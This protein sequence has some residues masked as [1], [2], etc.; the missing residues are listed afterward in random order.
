[1]KPL[2]VS[3][4]SLLVLA[5][6]ALFAESATSDPRTSLSIGYTGAPTDHGGKDCSTCHNSFASNSDGSGSVTLQVAPYNPSTIQTIKVIVNH[7]HARR[8][9]FQLTARLVSDQTKLAGSFTASGMNTQVR[10]DNGT[11][12]GAPAPA[13]VSGQIEYAEHLNAPTTTLGAGFTFDIQ[14]MPPNPEVGKVIFYVS[15]VAA[16][17]DN[18]PLGDHVYT[19]TKTVDFTGGCTATKAPTIRTVVNGASFQTSFSSNAIITVYGDGFTQAGPR[20]AGLGDFENGAFPTVL[21]CVALEMMGPGQEHYVRLPITY[22]ERGQVNA[23]APRFTGVGTVLLRAVINPDR[24]DALTSAISHFN[25]LQNVSPAF[26]LFANTTSI[27][28]V[29]PSGKLVA[30]PNVVN[31]GKKANSGDIVILFGTGFGDTKTLVLAGHVDA[32]INPLVTQPIVTIGGLPL[33]SKDILYAGLAPQAI[34]GLYQFNLRI[35]SGVKSG[36][37]EVV[38]KIGGQRTQLGASLPIQ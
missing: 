7:P 36:E 18:S 6:A 31:S 37:A 9:G 11:E 35:P 2:R 24:A 4:T 33:G 34:S 28:A 17:D 5:P 16:D 23:Q 15:A 3:L 22:V 26:F 10:I 32:G 12:F 13:N 19:I 1:M 21:S 30:D 25:S 14:W 29:F 27:A 8:W 20:I 38:I